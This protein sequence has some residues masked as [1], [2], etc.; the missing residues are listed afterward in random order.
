VNLIILHFRVNTVVHAVSCLLGWL[1]ELSND[2]NQLSTTHYALLR[3]DC[4]N[5]LIN[6]DLVAFVP[7][8]RLACV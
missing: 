8:R 1:P 6:T 2:N 5:V 7:T 4:F 3:H